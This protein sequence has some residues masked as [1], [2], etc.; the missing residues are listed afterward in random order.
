MYYRKCEYCGSKLDPGER[1]DYQKRK[2]SSAG[3]LTTPEFPKEGNSG[4]SGQ[5]LKQSVL[6]AF[7]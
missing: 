1:C 7:K 4:Q 6:P 3:P 5:A 2:E